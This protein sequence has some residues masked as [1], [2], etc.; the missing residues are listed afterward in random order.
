[1]QVLEL[2]EM[3]NKSRMQ[4]QEQES[5]MRNQIETCESKAQS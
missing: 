4:N 5:E 1:M 2:E 3:L